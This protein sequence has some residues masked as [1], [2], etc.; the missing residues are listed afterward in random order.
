MSEEEEKFDSLNQ[1]ETLYNKSINVK[2]LR[3]YIKQG[4]EVSQKLKNQD[5]L[6][7]IG[8]TGCGKSTTAHFLLG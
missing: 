2:R 5:I 8:K 3:K 1:I 6:L 7:L 4:E